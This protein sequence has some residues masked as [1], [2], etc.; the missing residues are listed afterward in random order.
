MELLKSFFIPKLRANNMSAT[1]GTTIIDQ[2][3]FDF[4]IWN[5]NKLEDNYLGAT[6][7]M[8]IANIIESQ[9]RSIDPAGTILFDYINK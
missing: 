7:R 5:I 2:P 1:E 3:A 9:W 8:Y 6:D 4:H